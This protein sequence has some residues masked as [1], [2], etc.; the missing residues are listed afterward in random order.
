MFQRIRDDAISTQVRTIGTM[1]LASKVARPLVGEY[2]ALRL[3][4]NG[5]A[6]Y[7]AM[8]VSALWWRI[9]VH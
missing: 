6:Q 1:I 8:H 9:L 4:F 2:V 7:V 3:G 5:P